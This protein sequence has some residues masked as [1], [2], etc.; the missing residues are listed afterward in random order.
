MEKKNVIHPKGDFFD[1]KRNKTT[2]RREVVAGCIPFMIRVVFF[3]KE[4]QQLPIKQ[5]M[6]DVNLLVK[7]NQ[8]FIK[9]S[10]RSRH[11]TVCFFQLLLQFIIPVRIKYIHIGALSGRQLIKVTQFLAGNSNKW[12]IRPTFRHCQNTKKKLVGI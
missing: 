11:L 3:R 7:L 5:L 9:T 1:L 10:P 4:I 2:V 8:V 12:N 6:K